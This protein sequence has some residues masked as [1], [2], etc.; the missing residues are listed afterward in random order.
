[1]R[2]LGDDLQARNSREGNYVECRD[3]IGYEAPFLVLKHTHKCD[4][5][6]ERCCKSSSDRVDVYASYE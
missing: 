1:M 2:S 4:I 6:D 5:E 3:D